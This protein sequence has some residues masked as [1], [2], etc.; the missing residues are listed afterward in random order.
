MSDL[1]LFFIALHLSYALRFD[2]VIEPR[3]MEN[4]VVIFLTLSLI[5][6]LFFFFFR[7]YNITWRFFGLDDALQ[8]IKA[9]IVAAAAFG[10]LFY[11]F[12][13]FFMPMPR[14]VILIDIF[15]SLMLTGALRIS[16]R[17]LSEQLTQGEKKQTLIIGVNPK[18]S[19][20][21]KVPS[22]ADSTTPLPL[23]LPCLKRMRVPSTPTSIRS[24]S[25]HKPT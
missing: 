5:K 9:H 23:L 2:F 7:V 12:Y 25:M 19:S 16:K 13:D 8:L 10:L 6:I 1:I 17:A 21:I 11:L 24:R 3:F 22:A 18:T 20:I 14:S 15:L 4:F